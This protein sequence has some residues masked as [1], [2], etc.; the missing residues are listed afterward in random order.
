MLPEG[1]GNE[2]KTRETSD[3]K[4]GGPMGKEAQNNQ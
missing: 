1:I 3:G 2:G 4:M